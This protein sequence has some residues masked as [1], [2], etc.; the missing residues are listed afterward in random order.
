MRCGCRIFFSKISGSKWQMSSTEWNFYPHFKYFFLWKLVFRTF[1]CDVENGGGVRVGS[2]V[3]IRKCNRDWRYR[4]RGKDKHF[5]LDSTYFWGW[6]Y[7][8]YITFSCFFQKALLLEVTVLSSGLSFVSISIF[9]SSIWKFFS[10]LFFFFA[11]L[12]QVPLFFKDSSFSCCFL[13]SKRWCCLNWGLYFLF[14]LPAIRLR[15]FTLP[16]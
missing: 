9:F 6:T 5:S 12:A 8:H 7:S 16:L 11:V 3:C 1:N 15:F 10:F 2:Y 4:R 14:S 13:T